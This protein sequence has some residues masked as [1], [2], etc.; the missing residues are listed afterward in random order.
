MIIGDKNHFAIE[1]EFEEPRNQ[2]LSGRICY[3]ISET[4]F[5][6]YSDVV[7]LRDYLLQ[8][9]A[10]LTFRGRRD[11]QKLWNMS[12][13]KAFDYIDSSLYGGRPHSPI[14]GINEITGRFDIQVPISV[15]DDCKI[16]LVQY[17]DN[18]KVF[19]ADRP[20]EIIRTV[21]MKKDTC[22]TVFAKAFSL[23]DSELSRLQ[24]NMEAE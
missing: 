13:E 14:D 4:K 6:N 1:L 3:W 24:G 18:E 2:W 8:L 9:P 15:F 7:S 19:F 22:D 10:V 12:D 5:G 17:D 16:Y 20:Y 23:L 21:V 11:D